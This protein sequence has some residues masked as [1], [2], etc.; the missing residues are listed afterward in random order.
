MTA[1]APVRVES[2]KPVFL[3]APS[4]CE[5]S[6]G[7][8][9]AAPPGPGSGVSAAPEWACALARPG[10]AFPPSLPPAS[11]SAPALLPAFE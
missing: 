8:C 9:P 10:F 6:R 11:P 3:V 4:R 5:Q 1:D 2:R 7:R